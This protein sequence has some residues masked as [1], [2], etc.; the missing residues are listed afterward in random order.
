MLKRLFST[1]LVLLL[2][3]AGCAWSRPVAGLRIHVHHE[4]TGNPFTMDQ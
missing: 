4:R 3:I 2:F 1:T